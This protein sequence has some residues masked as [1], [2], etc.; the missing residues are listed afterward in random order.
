MN[1]SR[2]KL[3]HHSA[4]MCGRRGQSRQRK[5]SFRLSGKS[6]DNLYIYGLHAVRAALQNPKRKKSS[7][8]ITVNARNRL[9]VDLESFS[10]KTKLVK[11]AQIDALVG[12]DKVHQ[13]VVLTCNPLEPLGSANLFQ[14]ADSDLILAL[15]QIT[16]PHN[17]G[18]ILRSAVAFNVDYVLTTCH[19]ST[20]ET[21]VMAK[22]ASGALDLMQ[23]IKVNNLVKALI[24]LNEMGFKSV[25]LDSDGDNLMETIAKSNQAQPMVLI[26]G[27]EGRGLRKKIRDICT[28]IAKIEMPGSIKSLNVSNSAALALY[29]TKNR[30]RFF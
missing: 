30:S 5:S 16:D 11:P 21:A 8:L 9:Q 1:H 2:F 26:I 3:T 18:A 22:S 23:I 7:L 12:D 20:V 10:I 17:F 15:D 27:S 24:E 6:L 28:E 14:I 19:Y 4:K 25:G 13:G 29:I